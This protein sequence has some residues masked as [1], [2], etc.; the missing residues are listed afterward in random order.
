MTDHQTTDEPWEHCGVL[1]CAMQ[2]RCMQSQDCKSKQQSQTTIPMIGTAWQHYKGGLYMVLDHCRLEAT[3][4]VAIMY[5]E[6]AKKPDSP[7]WVRSLADWNAVVYGA[8]R[9]QL[10]LRP[11]SGTKP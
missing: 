10:A 5:Q 6:L 7:K 3:G 9:F 1:A 2:A 8:P 4:E 11:M